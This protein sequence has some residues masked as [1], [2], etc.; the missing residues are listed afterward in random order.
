M[1]TPVALVGVLFAVI[2][3]YGIA[4]YVRWKWVVAATIAACSI[5]IAMLPAEIPEAVG[6]GVRGGA[7]FPTRVVGACLLSLLVVGALL[8]LSGAISFVLYLR[9]TQLPAQA[10]E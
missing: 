8:M 5:V 6:G 10:V 3:T 2:Y 1:S 7:V 9:H 4:R